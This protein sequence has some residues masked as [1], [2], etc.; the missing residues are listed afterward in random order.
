MIG[1]PYLMGK[2]VRFITA[3]QEAER[4]VSSI[5]GRIWVKL[6]C[7]QVSTVVA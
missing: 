7:F 6:A 5:R 1:L 3:K 2:L 4:R